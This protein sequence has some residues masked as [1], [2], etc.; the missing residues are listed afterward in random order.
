MVKVLLLLSGGF[1]SIV[2]GHLMLQKDPS[3]EI[4]GLHF[5]QEPFTDDTAE[6]K[7]VQ[8]C[9]KIGIKQM[10]VVTIG[11]QLALFTKQCDHRYYY[12][13]QRRFMW[14]IA[15]KIAHDEEASYLLTGE[16][17]GQVSSQTLHHVVANDNAISMTILRPLLTWI[18]MDIIALAEKIGTYSISKGPEF[19]SVLG[20]KN[21]IT[22]A[23][24]SQLEYEEKKVDLASM[25]EE[26]LQTKKT[27]KFK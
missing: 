15:E 24:V 25:I 1:D 11:E 21:P 12:P 26:G 10:L 18:K 7:C 8:L 16:N 3:L 2:A 6:K 9:K 19:C 27:I 22:K 14:R 4:V 17:L 5:S 20:P 13:L 23:R